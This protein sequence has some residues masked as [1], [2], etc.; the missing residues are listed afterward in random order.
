MGN[1]GKIGKMKKDN[2]QN[3]LFFGVNKNLPKIASKDP[4]AKTPKLKGSPWP[5]P[6]LDRRRNFFWNWY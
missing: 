1:L 4:G 5:G 2:W 3:D 6:D